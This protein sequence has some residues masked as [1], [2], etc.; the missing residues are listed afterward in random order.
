MLVQRAYIRSLGKDKMR[1]QKGKLPVQMRSLCVTRSEYGAN[2]EPVWEDLNEAGGGG[3]RSS[4]RSPCL[5]PGGSVARWA[6]TGG[7]SLQGLS[8]DSAGLNLIPPPPPG[9]L[10]QSIRRGFHGRPQPSWWGS[11]ASSHL[12]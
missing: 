1:V 4:L 9:Q 2:P 10:L 12:S 7:S 6:G 5:W 3:S 11:P 8:R